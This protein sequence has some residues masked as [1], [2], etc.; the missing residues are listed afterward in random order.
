MIPA[1]LFM[2]NKF[3]SSKTISN[4]KLNGFNVAFLGSGISKFNLSPLD[5]L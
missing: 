5:T 3:L 4:L 2:T 1:G